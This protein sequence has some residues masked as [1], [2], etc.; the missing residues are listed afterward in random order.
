MPH[1]DE[2]RG[3]LPRGFDI[4]GA[5]LVGGGGSD[6]DVTRALEQARALR[7]LLFGVATS[8]G[9]VGGHMDAATGDIRFVVSESAGT[10]SVEGSAVTWEDEPGRLLWEKGCLLR[11]ELPLKL[12]LYLRPDVNSGKCSKLT[13]LFNHLLYK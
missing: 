11:C 12:P 10:D 6:A 4:V 5:L 8:H 9:L 3:L 1:A 7:E 2:I 13:C